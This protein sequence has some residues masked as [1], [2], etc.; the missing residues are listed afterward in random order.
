MEFENSIGFYFQSQK[1]KTDF[2]RA[3]EAFF[4]FNLFILNLRIALKT[5][6]K[7]LRSDLKNRLH[8][9]CFISKPTIMN[10]MPKGQKAPIFASSTESDRTVLIHHIFDF[11]QSK[12][13]I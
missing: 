1:R 4:V 7:H 2:L 6:V 13:S 12:T 9:F 10:A 5:K 8:C 11:T 3:W